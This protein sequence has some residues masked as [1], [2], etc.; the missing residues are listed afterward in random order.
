[1][2]FS[3]AFSVASGVFV[4]THPSRFVIRCMC[5]HCKVTK[6]QYAYFIV[7]RDTPAFSFGLLDVSI[8][9]TVCC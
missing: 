4:V 8:F 9:D 6:G 5:I 7:E 3:K 2:T 1:M